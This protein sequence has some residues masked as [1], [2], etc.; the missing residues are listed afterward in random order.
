MDSLKRFGIQDDSKEL[1]VINISENGGKDDYSLNFIDGQEVKVQDE[2]FIKTVD[3]KIIK[4]VS[5][6]LSHNLLKSHY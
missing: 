1:V 3:Y 6:N 5:K 2:E 4:K